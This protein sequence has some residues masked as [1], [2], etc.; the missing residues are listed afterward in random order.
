MHT[1][2]TRGELLFFNMFPCCSCCCAAGDAILHLG[3]QHHPSRVTCVSLSCQSNEILNQ[4]QHSCPLFEEL[5]PS[6]LT[7]TQ[8][9]RISFNFLFAFL[10]HSA[11]RVPSEEQLPSFGFVLEDSP[12]SGL[13]SPLA[14]TC[15]PSSS[16]CLLALALSVASET[17]QFRG[18]VGL[19]PSGLF[20][21]S[22]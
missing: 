8:Q 17:V 1:T 18:S 3:R 15:F 7:C 6:S 11:V 14:D 2:H 4:Q 13:L 10:E 16:S 9:R 12:L 20:T 21:R 19:L 22:L 5:Y